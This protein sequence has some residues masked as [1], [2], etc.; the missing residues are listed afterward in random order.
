MDRFVRQYSLS[1][2]GQEKQ[3]KLA[4]AKVLIIGAG[5][6]GC[7]ALLYLAAAGV[8]HITVVDGDIVSLSNL[9]RQVLFGIS[10]IGKPKVDVVKE[11][12]SQKYND[13]QIDGLPFYLSQENCLGIIENHDLVID[14]SDNFQ[15]RYMVN[16]ACTLLEKPL[17][18]GSIF[19]NEGQVSFLN[20]HGSKSVNYRDIFPEPP[21]AHE[22]LNCSETGVLGVL[23][24]I[25][26]SLQASEAIKFLAGYGEVLDG[27]LL[28][29]DLLIH[30]STIFEVEKNPETQGHFPK[31]PTE[32]LRMNY[33]LSCGTVQEITWETVADLLT[34]EDN[35]LL[36]IREPHEMPK[37]EKI[38]HTQIPMSEVED[39]LED[40]AQKN[41]IL[42]CCQSGVR[43]VKTAQKLSSILIGKE[44][45]S[46]K[47][48][49]NALSENLK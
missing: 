36:D 1:G 14:G 3:Q 39:H 21:E 18:M 16:D 29:Y 46:I 47:G 40:F 17:I 44:F 49:V 8:G 15:T 2:F 35:L 19:Q 9:N 6:L 23:P 27:K 31:T 12:F 20:A 24:G 30:N 25:I 28:I 43:S 41:R 34:E 7:P 42:I 11:Y 10:D 13:I 22:V 37:L 26:G 38:D 5:G 45:F 33:A 4:T 32:F 48:G